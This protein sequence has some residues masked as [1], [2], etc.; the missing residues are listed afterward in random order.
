MYLY[1]MVDYLS[2]C[3]SFHLL[4]CLQSGGRSNWLCDSQRRTLFWNTALRP[5]RDAEETEKTQD[6]RTS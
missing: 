3:L 6:Q 4:H 5:T 2:L 1:F